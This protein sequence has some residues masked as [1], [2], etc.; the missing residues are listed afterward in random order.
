M[1]PIPVSV[2]TPREIGGVT[3]SIPFGS[4]KSHLQIL[5][6]LLRHLRARVGTVRKR[7]IGLCIQENHL[8]KRRA[9]QKERE[10]ERE[11]NERDHPKSAEAAR[12][13]TPVGGSNGRDFL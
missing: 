12:I 1:R 9:K 8:E 2:I 4:I 3:P 11:R 6:G 5:K 13:I 7:P 10:R